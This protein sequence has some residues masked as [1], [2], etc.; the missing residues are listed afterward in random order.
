MAGAVKT[1]TAPGGGGSRG[2]RA[3][4]RCQGDQD[5]SP[6]SSCIRPR[7]RR[8]RCRRCR[9]SC[10]F[11]LL[12]RRHI[13][14]RYDPRAAC[15]RY[16]VLSRRPV[17]ECRRRG[18]TIPP[19]SEPRGRRAGRRAPRGAGGG[20]RR[21]RWVVGWAGARAGWRECPACPAC[22]AC[23]LGGVAWRV[24]TENASRWRIPITRI[25][26]FFLLPPSFLPP[27]RSTKLL[28]TIWIIIV[29]REGRH[30]VK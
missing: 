25:A 15:C 28:T 24:Q 19:P 18:C 1:R 7:C 10:P 5:P 30:G 3:V 13:R 12:R 17:G 14:H 29:Q 16:R 20:G 2:G 23:R 21:W 6:P 26:P 11:L 9:P 8:T 22:C 27:P 4:K